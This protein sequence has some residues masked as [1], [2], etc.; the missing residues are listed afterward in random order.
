MIAAARLTGGSSL[1]LF[2]VFLFLGRFIGVD[3]GLSTAAALAY[4]LDKNQNGT[5]A[6]FDLGG[7]TFDVTILLLDDGVFQV[8]S[9][10]GDSALGGD[11]FD[12]LIAEETGLPVFPADDPLTCVARGGGRAL[13]LMDQNNGDFFATH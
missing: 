9:T 8:K 7:G 12:R 4:G 3:L 2:C 6:V 5:F 10:G 1:L 11:D 13:E